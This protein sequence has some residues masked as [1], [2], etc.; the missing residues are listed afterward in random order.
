MPVFRDVLIEWQGETYTVTP[1]N[2]L[3]RKIE[4]E[5]IELLDVITKI[6]NGKAPVSE[7]AFILTEFINSA[8]GRTDED[9]TL[10]EI[11]SALHNGQSE[12]FAAIATALVEA[13]TPSEIDEKKHVAP[14]AKPQRKA[15]AKPQRKAGAKPKK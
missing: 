6:S 12:Q 8:G 5:G 15:G 14:A 10:G 1:S 4:G 2:R 9:T 7:I 13:I 11:M 3:L